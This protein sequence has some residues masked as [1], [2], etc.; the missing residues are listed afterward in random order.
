MVAYSPHDYF[1]SCPSS[2]TF[3]YSQLLP[4]H[5]R[6]IRNP[7][8]ILHRTSVPGLQIR[9]CLLQPT[10]SSL[11]HLNGMWREPALGQSPRNIPVVDVRKVFV[12]LVRLTHTRSDEL[13]GVGNAFV[14]LA[15]QDDSKVAVRIETC[16]DDVGVRVVL[17]GRV[18]G[19][20]E[21]FA[22]EC[23]FEAGD[24]GVVTFT[25]VDDGV[26]L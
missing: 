13:Y 2:S 22:G 11:N 20:L 15:R 6:R 21:L 26:A 25:V 18:E 10:Q 14:L 12:A 23:G 24:D 8:D 7:E 5:T 19:V 17:R 3:F 9:Q 16:G 1:V 4:I